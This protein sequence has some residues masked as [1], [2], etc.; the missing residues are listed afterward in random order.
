V[1]NGFNL[2]RWFTVVFIHQDVFQRK[3]N[4]III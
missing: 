1:R 2:L 3:F 4:V